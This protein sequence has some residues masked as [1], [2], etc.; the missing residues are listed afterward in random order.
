VP[1][2][3]RIGPITAAERTKIVNWSPIQGRYD[4]LVDRESAFELLKAKA[5]RVAE[6]D[7]AVAEAKRAEKEAAAEAKRLAAEEKRLAGGG[8]QAGAVLARDDEPSTLLV[9]PRR[10]DR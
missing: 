7:A 1:P 10:H 5:L 2:R 8:A 9:G 4:T 3:S 6:A